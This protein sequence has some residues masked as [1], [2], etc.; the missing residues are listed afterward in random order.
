MDNIAII[1]SIIT[2]LTILFSAFFLYKFI[3]IKIKKEID[4]KMSEQ[5]TY[6][7]EQVKKANIIHIEKIYI[8]N[9]EFK[10]KKIVNDE[11]MEDLNEL[12]SKKIPL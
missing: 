1:L 9:E 7:E 12:I 6:L 10:N 2:V 8:N 11:V 4:K 5:R 3:K